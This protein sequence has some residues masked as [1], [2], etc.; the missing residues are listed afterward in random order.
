MF[1]S[2]QL[3]VHG[4]EGLGGGGGGQC[5][6]ELNKIKKILV[7]FPPFTFGICNSG[8]M[9]QMSQFTTLMIFGIFYRGEGAWYL[10][11]PHTKKKII[12]CQCVP[13]NAPD[14]A[15]FLTLLHRT[16]QGWTNLLL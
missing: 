9:L 15:I 5:H 13:H 10:V 1:P 6:G 11:S 12:T 16:D 14:K 4:R 7:T 8:L 2:V 3:Q